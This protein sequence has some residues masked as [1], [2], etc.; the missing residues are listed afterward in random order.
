[1]RLFNEI[2]VAGNPV[3]LINGDRFAE[4]GDHDAAAIGPGASGES[5]AAEISSSGAPGRAT[6]DAPEAPG[7][8]RSQVRPACPYDRSED[9]KNDQVADAALR[10]H[11]TASA[12]R[13]RSSR[14]ARSACTRP[15]PFPSRSSGKVIMLSLP[16]GLALFGAGP[17][18]SKKRKP[19][20]PGCVDPV[21]TPTR[22]RSVA[23]IFGQSAVWAFG[24]W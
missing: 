18:R 13:C 8:V 11:R 16:I 22:S 15:H 1:M 17:I 19:W 7:E 6:A 3:R 23:T 24:V 2:T 12:R 10:G 14:S 5:E 21:L 20:T 4:V 9:S